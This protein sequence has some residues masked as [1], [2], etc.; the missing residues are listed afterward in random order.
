MISWREKRPFDFILLACA[1]SLTVYGLL[2][3]YSGS[4]ASAGGQHVFADH[5]PRGASSEL[6]R[7]RH[8]R[9]PHRVAAGL[10]LPGAGLRRHVLRPHRLAAVRAY[11]RRARLRLAALD[12]RGGHARPAVR[13]RQAHRHP[14][15]VQVLH[16]QR[17]VRG[18]GARLCHLSGHRVGAGDAGLR[19]AG[20]GARR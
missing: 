3:I 2:L 13:D 20:P 15:A 18:H 1:L 12:R 7:R 16:R 8:R 19:R 9:L 5:G 4:V 14:G 6:R 10:S 11:P 17:G